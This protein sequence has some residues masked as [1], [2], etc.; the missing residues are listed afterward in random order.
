MKTSNAR[1]KAELRRQYRDIRK[2][3]EP[4]ARKRDSAIIRQRILRHPVW[5]DARTVL[6]YVSYGAEVDTRQILVEA[7]QQKKRL[8]V[9]CLSM[10]GSMTLLSELHQLSDLAPGFFKNVLEP[11]PAVRKIVDPIEVEV[12]LVPGIAFDR[13][14]GRL[15]QGGGHF[16]RILPSMSHGVRWGLAFSAQIHPKPLPLEAHDMPMNVIVTEESFLEIPVPQLK[17]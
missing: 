4:A 1:A 5:Q 9:P 6:V 14:G 11:P 3:L 16:D 12:A 7:L 10:E 15:G 8:I 2:A 13:Q 17:P